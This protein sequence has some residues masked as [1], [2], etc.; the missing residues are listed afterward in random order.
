MGQE[1]FLTRPATDEWIELLGM[2]EFGGES[3]WL[4]WRAGY[5]NSTWDRTI[6][7]IEGNKITIDVP[8]TTALDQKYGGAYLH[9][10]SWENRIQNIGIENLSLVSTY[11][12][13]NPKDE[14]HCWNAISFENA[15]N[16]WVRQVTFQHFAG[17]AVITSYSIHY[18]KLYE[19]T[20]LSVSELACT[21]T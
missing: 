1:I 7:N 16:C 9:T 12:A 21:L 11:N 20:L 14:E 3:G 19:A 2:K 6:T 8:I 13:E 5:H 15:A 4:G 10:A 17:S 18:T